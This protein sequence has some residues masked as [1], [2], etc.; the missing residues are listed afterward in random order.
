MLIDN[1]LYDKNIITDARLDII[2]F[3]LEDLNNYWLI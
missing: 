2:L 1:G 3:F